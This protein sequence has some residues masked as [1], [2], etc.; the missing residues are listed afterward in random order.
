V[1]IDEHVAVP[2][3]TTTGSGLAEMKVVSKTFRR[4]IANIVMIIL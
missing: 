4:T 1:Y 2:P 3:V